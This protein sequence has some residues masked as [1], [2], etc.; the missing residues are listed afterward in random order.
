VR[1]EDFAA[2]YRA[3]RPALTRFAATIVGPDRAGDV[4]ADAVVSVMRR[5]LGDGPSSST[6]PSSS[7][8]VDDL[9]PYTY[10]AVANAGARE[11]RT[12]GRRA[13]REALAV[14]LGADRAGAAV[15]DDP[16][17]GGVTL[18]EAL[19]RLSARQRAVVHLTYWEDLTPVDVATRLG[20]SEGSVRRHLARARR[21]L[22]RH[23]VGLSA[24]TTSPTPQIG[25]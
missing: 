21:N 24:S 25:R 7:S 23:L 6:S 22:R 3:E 1:D 20:I 2:F 9:R 13:R 19:A 12:I 14:S 5:V 10:R 4:V 15:A 17:P 8:V 16:D 18:S 11:W